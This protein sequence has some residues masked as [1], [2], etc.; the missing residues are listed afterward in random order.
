M[1]EYLR[2]AASKAREFAVNDQFGES[3]IFGPKIPFGEL[4]PKIIF[5]SSSDFN[6]EKFPKIS[7]FGHSAVFRPTK[8]SK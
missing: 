8:S 2:A 1:N 7:K 3:L 4:F 5:K 6:F